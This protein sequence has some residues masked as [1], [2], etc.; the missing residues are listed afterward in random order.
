MVS[1]TNLSSR[2]FTITGTGGT[3]KTRL[4]LEHGRAS[5]SRWTGG[6]WICDLTEA[7]SV[8]DI[9]SAVADA[10]SV[11]LERDPNSQLAEAIRGRGEALFIFDNFEQIVD[12]AAETVGRWLDIAD[13]ATF[14]V[15]SRQPLRLRGEHVYML[16]PFGPGEAS[17]LFADR[18]HQADRRFQLTEDNRPQIEA[19][20]KMLDGLPLAIELAAARIRG[21]PPA[22]LMNRLQKRFQLL[23]SRSP[24]LTPRQR[25]L[26]AT[27]QWSWDLLR[28]WEQDCL[29]Q[30]A[31]FEGGFTFEAAEVIIDLSAYPQA[32]WVEDVLA[33]LAEKSLLQ[34]RS[35]RLSMLVSIQDFARE[36]A[37]EMEATQ[38]RHGDFFATFG[39]RPALEALDRHGD[40]EKLA[41]LGQ[42]ID[43]LIA[44]CK[45]AARGGRPQVAVDCARAT[46]NIYA[47]RGPFAAGLEL[48]ADL[49][50][51][52]TLADPRLEADVCHMETRI[53]QRLGEYAAG[54]RRARRF[55]ELVKGIDDHR[56]EALALNKCGILLRYQG[57]FDEALEVLEQALSIS[58]HHRYP[59]VQ[60]TTLN[61][62]ANI[63]I[64]QNRQDDAERCHRRA[65]QLSRDV[66][67]RYQEAAVLGNLGAI[68]INLHRFDEAKAAFDAAMALH[69]KG[70]DL[71]GQGILYGNMGILEAKRRNYDDARHNFERALAIQRDLKNRRSMGILLGNLGALHF[72]RF[73]LAQARDR[74]NEALQIQRQIGNR[75]SQGI[76]LGNLGLVEQE[77]GDLL[78]ALDLFQRA[79][80]IL[81]QNR[82]RRFEAITLTHLGEVLLDMKRSREA[83]EALTRAALAARTLH[84]ETPAV[85]QALQGALAAEQGDP[86]RGR[87]LVDAALQ[88]LRPFNHTRHTLKA[89]CR[90]VAILQADDDLVGAAQALQEV[91]MMANRHNVPEDTAVM[92]RI[93][94]LKRQR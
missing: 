93:G 59:E 50:T 68:Y 6:V 51:N 23:Q 3:G 45:T 29:A 12:H 16:E 66:G 84:D 26:R 83:R 70:V 28:P 20:V 37:P 78:G 22:R 47:L 79:I 32:P 40:A 19:L 72:D 46:L 11:P 86:A 71:I 8:Q 33:E 62:M 7:W 92:T 13:R 44:A 43:N 39:S 48:I 77:S 94:D 91:V 27:L 4:A 56:R 34:T 21:L 69:K 1:P 31:C 73:E 30:A 82:L 74:L 17:A 42:E 65:L 18:A 64:K 24:D 5:L 35:G 89:L 63:F 60:A 61:A 58:Q 41:A 80:P 87:Q 49:R 15:T 10:L 54:L 75:S 57:Y 9:L 55:Y 85:I 25:T 76:L 38:R 36:A 90:K 52:A 2:L 81:H 53:H 14:L 67:D 88:A